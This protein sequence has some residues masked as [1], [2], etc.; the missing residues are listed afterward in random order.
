MAKQL[1]T[2]FGKRGKTNFNPSEKVFARLNVPTPDL[3]EIQVDIEDKSHLSKYF[4]VVEFSPSFT[5]GK[6]S[7]SFNGTD[8][9][10]DGTEIKMQVL[11]SERNSL[12]IDSPPMEIHY[13]D[14]AN[15]TTA[16]HI[17]KEHTDLRK[18]LEFQHCH[19]LPSNF[20]VARSATAH[21]APQA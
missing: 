10:K 21:Q 8:F 12:Y 2:G 14:L 1:L 5:A 17:N 4:Q 9:L 16:I 7:F 18:P 3:D 13:I 15:F 20:I 6:N 19:I 11:D